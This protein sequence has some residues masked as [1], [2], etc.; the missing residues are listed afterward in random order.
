[1][2]RLCFLACTTVPKMSAVIPVSTPLDV[3]FLFYLTA[4]MVFSFSFIF[5]SFNIICVGLG[6]LFASFIA[7]ILVIF[8]SFSNLFSCLA[9][10]WNSAELERAGFPSVRVAD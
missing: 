3:T 1:M 2:S 10:V 6:T 4:F 7:F 9:F 5:R 8:L